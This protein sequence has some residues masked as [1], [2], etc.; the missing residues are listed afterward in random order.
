M[1]GND[2]PKYI[3]LNIRVKSQ[4]PTCSAVCGSSVQL[5]AGR[6]LALLLLDSSMIMAASCDGSV[7]M[8]A[9]AMAEAIVL[10]LSIRW[11]LL[12]GDTQLWLPKLESEPE[13]SPWSGSAA[14]TVWS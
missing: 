1:H 6:F 5:T 13:P 11:L 9:S 3:L 8:D 14:L 10:I 12:S 7:L 4:S 2:Q